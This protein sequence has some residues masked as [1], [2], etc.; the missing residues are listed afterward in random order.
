MVKVGTLLGGEIN[1]TR[2]QMEEVFQFE[3][4]LAEIYEP[5]ERLRNMEEIYHK[6]TVAELQQLAPAVRGWLLNIIAP[7][8]TRKLS[9]LFLHTLTSFSFLSQDDWMN[10][11]F[12]RL[13]KE[14]QD[15]VDHHFPLHKK[16][17]TLSFYRFRLLLTPPKHAQR[18]QQFI[19]LNARSKKW[20]MWRDHRIKVKG[21]QYFWQYKS[22]ENRKQFKFM[23]QW[24][25][26]SI[27]LTL[28]SRITCL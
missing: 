11:D 20:I 2:H 15:K 21:I 8:P 1:T 10:Q 7:R 26:L 22:R 14:Y 28:H 6:M 27:H 3:K 9:M 19:Y 23:L 16:L 25:F 13:R 12:V 17:I 4:K 24:D 5:K 18:G